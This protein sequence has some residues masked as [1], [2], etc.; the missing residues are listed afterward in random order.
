VGLEAV[1]FDLDGLICDTEGCYYAATAEVCR[2]HGVELTL[3][4][5][6]TT[7]GWAEAD[8]WLDRLEADVGEA[9]PRKELMQ[10]RAGLDAECRSHLTPLPGV[11]PLMAEVRHE[12]LRVGVVSHA[13][14]MWIQEHLERFDMDKMVDA[15]TGCDVVDERPPAPDLYEAILA[16]LGVAPTDAL[17]V[18]DSQ[19]GVL[20]AGTAGLAC[21]AVPNP[22]TSFTDLSRADAVVES[23]QGI[24][25][26][27]HRAHHDQPTRRADEHTA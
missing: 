1:I 16:E 9:L 17:A 4:E 26:A 5:W 14:S 8:R 11:V 7:A 27:V 2:R 15:R 24:A 25:L 19:L 21:L 20:A 18:E 13:S 22:I 12:H 23:L 6:A 10:L 3:E